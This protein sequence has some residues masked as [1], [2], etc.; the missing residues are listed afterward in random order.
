MFD[1]IKTMFY[2]S[3]VHHWTGT[4]G[5]FAASAA[6][7]LI[8]VGDE[9]ACWTPHA[10][11][12]VV[13]A[14]SDHSSR[15]SGIAEDLSSDIDNDSDSNAVGVR[16]HQFAHVDES[17]TEGP[18]KD[19]FFIGSDE[20]AMESTGVSAA[21]FASHCWSPAL[22]KSWASASLPK[23]SLSHVDI[24]VGA[25]TKLHRSQPRRLQCTSSDLDVSFSCQQ[26]HV[27]RYFH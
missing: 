8:A 24:H 7:K 14:I 4:F 13:G 25:K 3:N 15:S 22:S 17:A 6:I 19:S 2:R 20:V 5:F 16:D 12:G 18:P 26:Q 9:E 11:K 27:S 21:P 1:I 23:A 10:L